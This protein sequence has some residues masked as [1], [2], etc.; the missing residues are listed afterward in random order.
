MSNRKITAR[1]KFS[2]RP[3]HF[4]FILMGTIIFLFRSYVKISPD[5][6]EYGYSRPIYPYIADILS[7]PGQW[8]HSPYSASQLFLSL[9]FFAALVWFCYNFYV[10]YKKKIVLRLLLETM[11]HG[12]AIVAGV[13]FFF[14]TT[15]GV[16]YLRQPFFISLNQEAPTTLDRFDYEQLGYDMVFLL[17]TLHKP[18]IFPADIH[19]LW[20]TDYAVDRALTK[21][22]AMISPPQTPCFPQTKFLFGNEFLNACGISG[23]FLPVFMEPHINSDLLLWER[24]FVMAH[25]KAH[26]MGFASETD[27]NFIA[28]LACLISESEFLRYSG[29]LNALLALR[30]YIPLK[31]WQKLIQKNLAQSVQEDIS[32]RDERIRRNRK[33]YARV[34]DLSHK[35]N[36]TYL[37]LNNQK[38]GIKSYQAALPHLTV[39]WKKNPPE[40]PLT[41]TDIF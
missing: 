26:F 16:N 17:N 30:H 7:L 32:A 6:I 21:V 25:E 15:W 13:Y 11:V 20:E 19:D 31:K 23:F 29:A 36:D 12:I 24:P 22:I 14:L 38:L 8:I 18:E 34:S 33:R 2:F 28:Y 35:I 3:W 9:A 37:K 5:K 27:A 41:K 40:F 4:V 39:W 10:S 1:K